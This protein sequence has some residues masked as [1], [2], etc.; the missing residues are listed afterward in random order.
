[1][2]LHR[3][4][5]AALLACFALSAQQR[6]RASEE[7][8][9]G[10]GSPRVIVLR[11]DVAGLEAAVAPG[12]GGELTSFKVRHAGQWLELIYR[13]RDY[14]DAAGFRGKAQWLWP[15]V[16]GQYLAG[17]TPASS[18]VDGRYQLSG[19][20]YP[21]PCHGFV[22]S[23]AFSEAGHSADAK[24]A[25][26]ALELSDNGQTRASYPFGFRLRIEFE[27]AGGRLA[28]RSHVHAAEGNSAAMPFSMG[29]HLSL[30]LPFVAGSDAAAM[31]LETPNSYQLLRDNH[32]LVLP[33]SRGGQS[34]ATPTTLSAIDASVALPLAGYGGEPYATLRDPQGLGLRI[35]QRASTRLDEPLVR[36]NL[37]GSAKQGYICPE[38]WFGVQNS[39]NHGRGAV[40]LK[41][42]ADWTWTIELQL[43]AATAGRAA[44]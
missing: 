23:M 36:F 17:E 1:M 14:G 30:K 10:A 35:S 9:A 27:L 26:V 18:C 16:G 7:P 39:L 13:A 31:S 43:D 40:Q 41:P 8:A 22:K 3:T 20:T 32:G 19:R 29:N 21:M 24:G 34:F 38:P 2:P 12:E 6:Y 37:Y 4:L 44:H 11:D 5:A 28:I 15:A 42:G 25:R 33:E